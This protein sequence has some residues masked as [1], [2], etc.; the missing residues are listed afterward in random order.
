MQTLTLVITSPR[1]S[2]NCLPL[3]SLGALADDPRLN[4]IFS[5]GA[6]T[7]PPLPDGSRIV[8]NHCPG[9]GPFT[10]RRTALALAAQ[11]PGDWVVL[12]ESHC[13]LKPDFFAAYF[14]A[15]ADHPEADLLFGPVVNETSIRP[16]EMVNFL[17][18]Y[19]AYWPPTKMLP[20]SASIANVAIRKSALSAADLAGDAGFEAVILPRLAQRQ[21]Y[22]P[23][24]LVDHV[25]IGRLGDF[26]RNQFHNGRACLDA[27]QPLL[28]GT[29]R[30]RRRHLWAHCAATLLDMPRAA[31]KS[32][33]GIPVDIALLGP[34][35]S[36]I[37]AAH[38]LG[39]VTGYFFGPGDSNQKID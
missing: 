22:V 7:A 34:K 21:A 37:G 38:T 2:V 1:S 17:Y 36:L 19:Y 6:V 31:R 3:R 24:A 12:T 30:A 13:K 10:L 25:E 5:S 11:Q 8:M 16:A 9:A 33:K 4:I 26:C 20:P 28:G 23:G 15:M 39:A 18:S 32:L 29:A 27:I 14:Q 35:L